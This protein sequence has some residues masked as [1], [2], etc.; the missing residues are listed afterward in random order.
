MGAQVN[1]IKREKK[2]GNGI[3]QVRKLGTIA[4]TYKNEAI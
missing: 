3:Y 2:R 4:S 1:K